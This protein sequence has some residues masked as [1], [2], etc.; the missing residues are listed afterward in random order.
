MPLGRRREPGRLEQ[1][2]LAVVAAADGPVTPAQVQAELRTATGRELA[3]TTVMTTLVR[4]YAKGAVVRQD[5]ARGFAYSL[6][7][8][9]AQLPAALTARQ[10][11]RLLDAEDDR[12]GALT[13][14]VA[15]LSP[16][17]EAFLATLLQD[18][19]PAGPGETQT[20]D[21]RPDQAGP[22]NLGATGPEP[23][24]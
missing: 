6:A 17:D 10:M 11:Q 18:R 16:Q 22:D 21:G 9:P 24:R 14:F 5:A 2:V 20:S 23:P 7:A 12:A 3:Y 1:E 4:L 19:S 13:R 8:I 15:A